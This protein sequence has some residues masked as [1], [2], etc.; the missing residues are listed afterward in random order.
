MSHKN[1]KVALLAAL[2]AFCLLAG[3]CSGTDT[4]TDAPVDFSVDIV[5][6]YATTTPAP[7]EDDANS[8]PLK[9]DANGNVTLSDANWIDSGF[10]GTDL[11]NAAK[12]YTQLR[13]GD[14]GSEV[15]N[16]QTRLKALEYYDGEVS[17]VFDSATEDAVKRGGAICLRFYLFLSSMAMASTAPSMPMTSV[18]MHRS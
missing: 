6:P 17:G 3:G 11:E 10:A 13:L 9:I 5:V 16:L 8:S 14:S 15:R 1:T 4:T 18:L 12:Y 7:V 2:L